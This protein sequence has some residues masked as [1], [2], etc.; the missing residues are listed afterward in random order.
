[1]RR[2]RPFSRKLT[3]AVRILLIRRRAE[4]G[5]FPGGKIKKFS[6]VSTDLISTANDG[7]SRL[8]RLRVVVGDYEMLGFG[9]EIEIV[10]I[11]EREI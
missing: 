4:D 9:W 2:N 5:L 3:I 7:A 10:E 1:M 11:V 6:H 8:G